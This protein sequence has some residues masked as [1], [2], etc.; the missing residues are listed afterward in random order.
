MVEVVQAFS[1]D[2]IEVLRPVAPGEN[3]LQ[4]G[5]D[6]LAGAEVLPAPTTKR[7]AG[8]CSGTRT[9]TT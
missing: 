4:I 6:V 8:S 2:E 1:R 3:S 5:E 7:T 9:W